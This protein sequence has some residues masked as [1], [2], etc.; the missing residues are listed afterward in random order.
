MMERVPLVISSLPLLP[1]TVPVTSDL[2]AWWQRLV[3]GIWIQ[4][5]RLS[6]SACRLSLTYLRLSNSTCIA[7]NSTT[8][9]QTVKKVKVRYPT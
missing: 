1:L 3:R 2:L 9:A 8:A 6:A 4:M 5:H 7:A